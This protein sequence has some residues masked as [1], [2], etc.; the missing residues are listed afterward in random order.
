MGVAAGGKALAASGLDASDIDLVLL[1]TTSP[2]TAIPG[3]APQ[4]AHQLGMPRPGAFDINA[5]CAGWC[6][7]LGAGADAI[8]S[9]SARNV[10]VV[11]GERLTDYTT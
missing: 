2:P 3:I 7:A 4:V 5:G 6:Y 1:A 11:G 8:R 10:L 9:G